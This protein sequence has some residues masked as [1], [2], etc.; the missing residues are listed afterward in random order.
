MLEEELYFPGKARDSPDSSTESSLSYRSTP[1]HSSSSIA[2]ATPSRAVSPYGAIPP[3]PSQD[4]IEKQLVALG[5]VELGGSAALAIPGVA[6]FPLSSSSL[7]NSSGS[8]KGSR[9]PQT[10]QTNTD[11]TIPDSIQT[12][13][14]GD[15]Q[16]VHTTDTA[17]PDPRDHA[18]LG[19]I[20]DEMH[21]LRFI[22]LYPLSILSS[23]ISLY[24]T[25]KFFRRLNLADHPLINS[26]TDIHTHAPITFLFPSSSSKNTKSSKRESSS[27]GLS[28]LPPPSP[29]VSSNGSLPI[30]GF[31][32]PSQ[33]R[34]S[35]TPRT[36]VL[37]ESL[38]DGRTNLDLP[39]CTLEPDP[40]A[41]RMHLRVR[42][43][44]VN[45]CAESMWEWVVA[46]QAKYAPPVQGQPEPS[47]IHRTVSELKRVDFDRL[48]RNFNL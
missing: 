16:L 23:C 46:F 34:V 47:A 48:L 22:N 7:G 24:F 33:K 13:K 40:N 4:E 8:S 43:G 18:V 31:R 27:S 2:V 3:E 17:P 11:I 26:N 42:V 32:G 39:A 5:L 15:E 38:A 36:F 25:S 44:D 6:S 19:A 35:Q 14:L 30:L 21:L 29:A 37:E 9:R 41:A 45:A 1:A 28:T 20:W 12:G 10:R